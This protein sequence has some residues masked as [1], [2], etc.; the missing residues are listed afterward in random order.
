MTNQN[1]FFRLCD[2]VGQRTPL[3]VQGAGGNISQKMTVDGREILRI[4]ASGYRLDHINSSQGYV[5]LDLKETSLKLETLRS[6]SDRESAYAKLL[7]E[8]VVNRSQPG[9]RASMETCFHLAL[10]APLV[11][12]F[13]SL[14]AVLLADAYFKNE[15]RVLEFLNKPG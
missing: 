4:K 12:H 11:V 8:S 14:P 10:E 15:K 6:A 7:S 13:H 1:D 5:D 3:W 2:K 9:E